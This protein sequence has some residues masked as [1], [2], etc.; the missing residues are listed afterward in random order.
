[1]LDAWREQQRQHGRKRVSVHGPLLARFLAEIA[2]EE[3]LLL[4]QQRDLEG[5]PI[6]EA[7]VGQSIMRRSEPGAEAEGRDEALALAALPH[8]EA[9]R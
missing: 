1:M 7:I 3:Q 5:L 2:T 9:S 4:Q 6:R 8:Y